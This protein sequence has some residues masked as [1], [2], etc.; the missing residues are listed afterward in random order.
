MGTH[1][2]PDG[3]SKSADFGSGCIH[4]YLSREVCILVPDSRLRTYCVHEI[5]STPSSARTFLQLASETLLCNSPGGGLFFHLVD[6]WLLN[7]F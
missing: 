7:D 1:V 2:I 5:K 3:D 6:K 4:G